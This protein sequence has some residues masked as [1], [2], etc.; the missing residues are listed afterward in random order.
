MFIPD[1]RVYYCTGPTYSLF[2][3]VL[4]KHYMHLETGHTGCFAMNIII[5]IHISILKKGLP[6]WKLT[7]NFP[8]FTYWK[9]VFLDNFLPCSKFTSRYLWKFGIRTWSRLSRANLI[10]GNWFWIQMYPNSKVKIFSPFFFIMVW[11]NPLTEI[12]IWTRKPVVTSSQWN[13]FVAE[14]PYVEFCR[15]G[16]WMQFI[17]L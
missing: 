6:I 14:S 13:N 3:L 1:S 11:V 4:S 8:N 17:L 9:S 10:I 7:E 12:E 15:V 16:I 5:S 2:G